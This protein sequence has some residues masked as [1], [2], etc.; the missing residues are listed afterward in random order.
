MPTKDPTKENADGLLFFKE[1]A[2]YFMDF[3]ET[4]FHKHKNPRR[5]V[6]FRNSDN[7]LVGANLQKY[8]TFH[9][10]ILKLITENFDKAT[11]SK[12]EKGVY[13]TT[14]PKNL[15]NLITLQ[16]ERIP[17]TQINSI[18]E[19]ITTAIEKA[20][21]LYEK[22]YDAALTAVVD[23]T[24]NI[25]KTDLLTPFIQSIE[26]PLQNLGLG[27]EDNIFVIEEELT[28]VFVNQLDDKISEILNHFIAKE[29]VNL[30]HEL[31][32]SFA[33]SDVIATLSAFF[34]NLQVA[35]LFSEVFEMERNK[36]ILDKQDFYL[37]F[38][39][40]SFRN[41]KYPI[42]YIPVSITRQ[43]ET[44]YL[45]FDSQIYINKRAL[46]FV[47][48]EF[49]ILKGSKGSLKSISERIVYLAQHKEDLQ[50]LL[51]AI[52]TE[53]ANFFDVNGRIDFKGGETQIA[54]GASVRLSN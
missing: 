38:G 6:K 13:K 42:F 34:E 35:D 37:Y 48:Q 9:R 36:S 3:L 40:V 53:I 52:L 47:V 49:N 21:T 50:D 27:D 10:L 8:E 24:T 51:S 5:S 16:I 17:T 39:D 4:D 25:L 18:V 45:E 44:L 32:K 31:G 46:E 33:P 28:A 19:K 29:E 20:G 23:A 15:L 22:E 11:L 7:L 12:I 14:L 54:K 30:Q 2:K 1:V 41:I 43:E 26:K